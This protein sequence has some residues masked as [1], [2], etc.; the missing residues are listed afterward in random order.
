MKNSILIMGGNFTNKGAEAMAYTSIYEI[1]T[2][3]PTANVVMLYDRAREDKNHANYQF[4]AALDGEFVR[5]FTLNPWNF[6]LWCEVIVLFLKNCLK[7]VLGKK[8]KTVFVG[9][10]RDLLE[11]AIAVVD[12]SGYAVASSWPV[13]ATMRYLNMI[14]LCERYEVPL[15]LMPQ[16][17]GP[18]DYQDKSVLEQ[19]KQAMQGAQLVFPREK[20]GFELLLNLGLKNVVLSTDLVL[21]NTSVDYSLLLKQMRPLNVEVRENSVAVLPNIRVFER[22]DKNVLLRA[23]QGAIDKLLELNKNVYLLRHSVEDIA[24]ARMIKEMYQ[25][26]VRVIL[27]ENEFTSYQFEELVQKF[28]Y[29]IASRYHS[30]V[31]AYKHGV[32]CIAVGWAVK[33]VELLARFEQSRYMFDARAYIECDALA[34]AVQTLDASHKQE[35]NT[36]LQHLQEIQ[37]DNCFDLVE[38]DLKQKLNEKAAEK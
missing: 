22:C 2:R 13:Q 12:I 16:S 32:P 38:K 11:Q 29:I 10:R 33:Y 3:F 7:K 35:K 1:K 27:I 25:D 4:D 15:Y 18:F 9:N 28:D 24:P 36:I 34:V 37:K 30:I 26:D 20:E 5:R 8:T 14:A 31:H 19:I 17:F 23:Y 6:K 21:Q